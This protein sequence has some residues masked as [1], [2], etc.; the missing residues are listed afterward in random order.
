MN[1]TLV[2]MAAGMGS[3]FGGLKQITPLGPNDEFLIDYSIYDAVKSGFN[4]VVFIIKEENYKLFKE[5]IGKRVEEYIKTE[6]VFQKLD[7]LPQGYICP[8]NRSKPWGTTHAILAAKEAV[9]SSF[10][11]INADDFYGYDAF[12]VASENLN[13]LKDN[14]AFLIGY[15]VCNTLSENGSVKRGI[16]KYN[17]NGLTEIDEA[18][19]FYEN[20]KIF[21]TDLDDSNLREIDDYSLVSMNMFGFTPKIFEYLEIEFKAFLNRNKNNLE[22]CESLIVD[23]VSNC[24]KEKKLQ[25]AV[26]ET[27]SKWYGVTYKEDILSVREQLRIMEKK[28]YPDNFWKKR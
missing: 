16:C 5:T 19:I 22:K 6:Y 26:L 20:N 9:D 10:I 7:C 3:R 4:K 12:C 17:N 27:I 24:I 13:D 18:K 25:V 2:I 23:D 28:F 21:A 1:K 11:I 8:L 15:N 14:E